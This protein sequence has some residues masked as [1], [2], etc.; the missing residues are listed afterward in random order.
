M[1]T[2][3]IFKNRLRL[4]SG[5]SLKKSIPAPL[6]F[7]KFVK[8]RAGVHSDTPAPEHLCKVG[9]AFQSFHVTTSANRVQLMRQNR[10]RR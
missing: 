10:K 7:S 6:L 5:P 3:L 4:H 1:Q 2:N 8:T 9:H